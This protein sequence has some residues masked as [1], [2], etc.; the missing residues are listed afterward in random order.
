M[1]Y[2]NKCYVITQHTNT[3]T[4]IFNYNTE[5]CSQKHIHYITDQT[6]AKLNIDFERMVDR[7]FKEVRSL[8]PIRM[9]QPGGIQSRC[10]HTLRYRVCS[11]YVPGPRLIFTSLVY[12]PRPG[13]YTQTYTHTYIYIYIYIYTHI[14]VP[15]CEHPLSAPFINTLS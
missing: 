8:Q 13:T 7:P 4:I 5:I 15:P 11:F 10:L 12:Y 1:P 9:A 6:V 14:H 3:H 2:L